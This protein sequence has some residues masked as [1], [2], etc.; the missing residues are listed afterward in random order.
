M[1][2]IH[3]TIWKFE[4]PLPMKDCEISVPMPSNH[5]IMSV[6]NQGNR[7]FVWALVDS[8]SQETWLGLTV[9]VSAISTIVVP[10]PY[11]L[12]TPGRNRHGGL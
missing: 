11:K 4:I 7:V 5:K 12:K 9:G 10:K 6:H 3:N 8:T 2:P 1:N